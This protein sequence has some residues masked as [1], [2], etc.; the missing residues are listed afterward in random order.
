[1]AVIAG[2]SILSIGGSIL[3][4]LTNVAVTQPTRIINK[5]F[6]ADNVINNYEWYRDAHGNFKAKI[7]QVNQYKKIYEYETNSGEKSRIRIDLAAIQQS[8]RDLAG[9]YNA[10]SLK[11]NRSI[12]RGT[13]VPE[14]LN[15]GD[16]E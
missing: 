10:N 7:S 4:T 1:M 9:R 13:N 11:I 14:T 5:T 15:M 8:C 3:G 16:C 2:V 6:D 12:F